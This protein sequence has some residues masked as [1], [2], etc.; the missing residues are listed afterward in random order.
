MKSDG[1]KMNKRVGEA[2]V[3]NCHIQSGE[4]TSHRLSERQQHHLCCRGY[5]H[6]CGTE[7]PPVHGSSPAQCSSLHWFNV[8]LASNWEW[9]HWEP[10]YWPYHEPP[11][12]IEWQG[13]TCSFLVDTKPLWH[14]AT[15]RVDQLAKE[16]VDHDMDPL[17]SIHYADVKPLVNSYTQQLVQVKWDVAVDGRDIYLLKPTLGVSKTFQHLTRAEEL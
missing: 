6:Q 15:M 11:L 13:H 14:W 9:R 16:T 12:F 7:L 10:F 1:S 17:V 5:S 2:E 3:I 8:L 4:T